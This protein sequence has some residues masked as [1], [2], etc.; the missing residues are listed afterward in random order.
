MVFNLT[1]VS[2][3]RFLP[4]ILL[5]VDLAATLATLT[6]AIIVNTPAAARDIY[7]VLVAEFTAGVLL[8]AAHVLVDRILPAEP[9]PVHVITR[10]PAVTLTRL[11]ETGTR[12]RTRT[13]D[14][15]ESRDH[16]CRGRS[17]VVTA[18]R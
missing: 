15:T 17:F 4:L 13:R 1:V 7:A 3:A 2:R 10:A 16:G 12:R 5:A 14:R 6:V 8:A 11:A 18:G 9:R